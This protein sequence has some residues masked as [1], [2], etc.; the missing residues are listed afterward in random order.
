MDASTYLR[1]KK[2]SLGQYIHTRKTMDA[3]LQTSIIGNNASAAHYVSPNTKTA[4]INPCETAKVAFT[5][6]ASAQPVRIQAVAPGCC[7][8]PDTATILPC[9]PMIYEP[10]RYI[11]TCKVLPYFATPAQQK[12]AGALRPMRI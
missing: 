12:E 1:R 10:E 8:L 4:P 11:P 7:P 6:S 5:G 9:C 2:E 3:G